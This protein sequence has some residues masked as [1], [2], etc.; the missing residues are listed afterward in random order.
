MPGEHQMP[1]PA[2]MLQSQLPEGGYE[3]AAQPAGCQT[4]ERGKARLVGHLRALGDP[5]AEIDVGL[6]PAAGIRRPATRCS[7]LPRLRL[8]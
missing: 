7:R 3:I 1:R 4:F 8:R 5:I 6:G 2:V